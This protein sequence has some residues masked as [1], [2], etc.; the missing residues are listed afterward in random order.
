MKRY[1]RKAALVLIVLVLIVSV[2]IF[3]FIRGWHI[4][5]H[6][7]EELAPLLKQYFQIKTPEGKWPFPTIIGF[8][9]CGGLRKGVSDWADYLVG[10]GYAT[11]LVDSFT[12]RGIITPDDIKDV[13]A[14]RKLWGSE[15][16]GDVLVS[17]VEARKLSFVDKD[18]LALFGWS[19][20]AW[21]IMDLLAMDP[22]HELP[23]NLSRSPDQPLTGVKAAV[24]FYP[25]CKFPAKSRGQG[26]TQNI[27]VLLLMAGK[28]SMVSTEACLKIVSI[29]EKSGRPI[30]THVYPSMDH[31]FDMRDEDLKE[32]Q[33][34]FI[35]N[36]EATHD[37]RKRVK[38]FLAEVFRVR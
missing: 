11:I 1:L 35:H 21:T 14:G 19:H 31:A 27:E 2:L 38:R 16:A 30:R 9:G 5:K 12:G 33:L 13:C 18:Q 26:W 8:H 22:P 4:K 7:P 34:P 29:L 3:G 37:A 36:S 25:Y 24:L 20:G 15:R 17:L 6:T 10:L 32:L 28:D 23:T